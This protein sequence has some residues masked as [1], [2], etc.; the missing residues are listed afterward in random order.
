MNGFKCTFHD[1]RHTFATMAIANGVDVRTVASYLG[2][3]SVSMTLD[4]YAD[5]D[6]EAKFSAVSKIENAF[7]D[8]MSR[9]IRED[10]RR[11]SA[12]SLN[13]PAE[14]ISFTADQLKTMLA[15]V[16]NADSATRY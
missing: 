2:H 16:E 6:P 9:A 3:S 12:Q 11:R 5:V 8:T 1:L 7:D 15:I 14:A 10:T 4:I 13:M